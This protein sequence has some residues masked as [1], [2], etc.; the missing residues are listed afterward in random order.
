ME[1]VGHDAAKTENASI[2]KKV[3][4][5][6]LLICALYSYVASAG[7]YLHKGNYKGNYTI[8]TLLFV[9]SAW[10]LFVTN[11]FEK[12]AAD[13]TSG[14]GGK[15]GLPNWSILSFLF[16]VG[17]CDTCICTFLWFSR[18]YA[19]LSGPV[20]GVTVLILSVYG[21]LGFIVAWLTGRNWRTVLLFVTV[22]PSLIGSV[23]LR[24]HIL[25]KAY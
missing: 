13:E 6:A 3:F 17:I 8:P 5:F 1:V 9:I 19:I 18:Q 10:A 7:M 23:V 11:Q 14:T 2:S 15:A 25:G 21:V 24:L 12:L 22:V 20:I 4:R 16:V